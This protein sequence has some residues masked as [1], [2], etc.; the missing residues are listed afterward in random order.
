MLYIYICVYMCV[1]IY[2]RPSDETLNLGPD[3]M[4]SLK[5]PGCPS[6]MSRCVT[7]ASWPNLPIGL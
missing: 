7:P 2:T 5:I 1:C 3:S 6:K 4:W